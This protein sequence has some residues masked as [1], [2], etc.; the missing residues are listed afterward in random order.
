MVICARQTGSIIN[1][2]NATK[3]TSNFYFI[4]F[5][6]WPVT[7][8]ACCGLGKWPLLTPVTHLSPSTQQKSII[9]WTANKG[10]F[11]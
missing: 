1:Y 2:E 5:I 7:G 6:F 4:I 3:S 10:P 8:E 11:N 9:V